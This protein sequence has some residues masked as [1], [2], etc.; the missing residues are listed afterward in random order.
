MGYNGNN[1][2]IHSSFSKANYKYGL[3]ITETVASIPLFLIAK[4]AESIV[5]VDNNAGVTSNG[6]PTHI[7]LYDNNFHLSKE[8]SN[9]VFLKLAET[10]EKTVIDNQEI[11]N[12]AKPIKEK[13]AK[14]EK[15]M[16]NKFLPFLKIR[17][18]NKLDELKSRL[19]KL[20][21]QK[22][23]EILYI[24]NEIDGENPKE[25]Q[26]L[27]PSECNV[28]LTYR[29]DLKDNPW[30]NCGTLPFLNKT[31]KY[32]ITENNKSPIKTDCKPFISLETSNGSIYFYERG[33]MIISGKK[34]FLLKHDDVFMCYHPVRVK[35]KCES[36]E[37][38]FEYGL[39]SVK[40]RKNF[41]IGL[42]FDNYDSGVSFAKSFNEIGKS[43]FGNVVQIKSYTNQNGDF[44]SFTCNVFV[45]PKI[46][47]NFE[48]VRESEKKFKIELNFP[49][50]LS[51]NWKK[52]SLLNFGDNT[53][54][55]NVNGIQSCIKYNEIDCDYKPIN[56]SESYSKSKYYCNN[57][58]METWEHTR[59]DGAPDM[60]Y[61]HNEKLLV[62]EYGCLTIQ[63]RIGL[64]SVLFSDYLVGE[65]LYKKITSNR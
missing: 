25:M 8:F 18:A 56:I 27:L 1:R 26:L 64:Y 15:R 55:I 3:R 36:S 39:L 9:V 20:E 2:K 31:E 6:K 49:S 23:E 30:N 45:L 41:Q 65:S 43:K 52:D 44:D 48:F 50:S 19:N 11:D 40:I 16:N 7:N 59:L 28:F 12:K 4:V 58:I 32:G 46:L 13:I 42:L 29:T 37:I 57:I 22:K 14:Y 61:L 24:H 38:S 17:F 47:N 5:N 53:L 35:E 51:F 54:Y 21:S 34:Y 63:S 60:R 62:I 10:Y 33:L